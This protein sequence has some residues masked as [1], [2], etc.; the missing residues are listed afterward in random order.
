MAES[1]KSFL[2]YCDQRSI[3]ELLS[4]EIAGKLL[5]HI[6]SYVNDEN[7]L[8]NDPMV[9]LAFEPIKLQLKRD[10]ITWEQTR[11]KRRDAGKASGEARKNKINNELTHVDFV[12]QV[13]TKRTVNDN[14]NVNVNENENNN[15]ENRKLKFASTL[16]I[17]LSKYSRDL[18]KEFY[19]YWTEPNKTNTKFRFELE[20]TWSLE[21]RLE[22]WAK[23]ANKFNNQNNTSP[24]LNLPQNKR[25]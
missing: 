15:I 10:L 4:D 25:L 11:E 20:K 17:Y 23:N 1:K 7:P 24:S 18:L 3:I 19:Q 12:E 16:E 5:K 21:R 6:Y 13:K 2:L 14:V 9:I 8:S 22:N